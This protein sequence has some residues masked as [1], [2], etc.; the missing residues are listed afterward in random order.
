MGDVYQSMLLGVVLSCFALAP[1]C[2]IIDCRQSTTRL[3]LAQSAHNV[4]YEKPYGETALPSRIAANL[5]R[6]RCFY[7]VSTHEIL[8]QLT[9]DK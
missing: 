1:V 3:G 8:K 7:P 9:T 2:Y 5:A 6:G 4:Q